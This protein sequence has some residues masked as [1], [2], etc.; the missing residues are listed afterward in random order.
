MRDIFLQGF[1]GQT[2]E[3]GLWEVLCPRLH[4]SQPG[5]GLLEDVHFWG[6]RQD[7]ALVHEDVTGPCVPL[8]DVQGQVEASPL[9]KSSSW[10]VFAF[11][12]HRQDFRHGRVPWWVGG[13]QFWWHRL[14]RVPCLLGLLET[15]S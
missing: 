10:S 3:V 14:A 1:P 5:A 8:R 11:H 13:G 9:P 12:L 4:T 15:L 6:R 2:Q 7:L